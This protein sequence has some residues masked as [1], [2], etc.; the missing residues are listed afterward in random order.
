MKQ[1]YRFLRRNIGIYKL[2]FTI[3]LT[4][5]LSLNRFAELKFIN[6]SLNRSSDITNVL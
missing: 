5:Q 3:S 1:K 6:D 4:K 2:L